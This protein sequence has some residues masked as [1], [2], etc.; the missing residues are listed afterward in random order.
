MLHA[1]QVQRFEEYAA[2]C[3]RLQLLD[4]S[5]MEDEAAEREY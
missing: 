1:G 2:I 4:Q 5:N 3:K